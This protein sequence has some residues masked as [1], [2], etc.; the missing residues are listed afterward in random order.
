M[1]RQD[2]LMWSTWRE[3]NQFLFEDCES[4]VLCLKSSFLRSL[5]DW[6]VAYVPNFSSSNL[7]DSITF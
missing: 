3:R 4:N 6:T 7:V 5:V 2:L 1:V